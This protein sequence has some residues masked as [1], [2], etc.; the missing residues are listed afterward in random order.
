MGSS[1]LRPRVIS[2][3]S[4]V[5]TLTNLLYYCS[6]GDKVELIVQVSTEELQVQVA[7]PSGLKPQQF[8]TTLIGEACLPQISVTKPRSTLVC[9]LSPPP[10]T[11]LFTPTLI[12]DCREEALVF[13]NTGII[14]CTVRMNTLIQCFI[15]KLCNLT[16]YNISLSEASKK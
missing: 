7:L 16:V 5:L 14:S 10:L 12:G 1:M 15:R 8:T 3:Q 6:Q 9:E 13:E 4:K 11:L 2:G